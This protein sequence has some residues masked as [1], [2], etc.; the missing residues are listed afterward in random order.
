M[1]HVKIHVTFNRDISGDL[2]ARAKAVAE[3][4]RVSGI[5]EVN[6]K[7]LER[8]GLLSG[9]VEESKIGEIRGVKG[10]GKV[11]ADRVRDVI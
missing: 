7:R 11:E 5:T 9:M 1:S 10:V 2:E 4:H 8:Y 3:I 6:Q